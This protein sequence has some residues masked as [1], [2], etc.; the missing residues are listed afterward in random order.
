MHEMGQGASLHRSAGAL[1]R[2]GDSRL[3]GQA[4]QG[5]PVRREARGRYADLRANREIQAGGD[6]E[7]RTTAPREAAQ[8]RQ[9]DLE[10]HLSRGETPGCTTCTL[11]RNERR[12]PGC[13]G[14]TQ[15]PGPE[16]TTCTLSGCTRCTR[17][18]HSR[19]TSQKE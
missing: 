15:K 9:A 5:I 19:R 11:R 13:T 1:P 18:F 4:W 3:C 16:C 8:E 17:T 6:G 12:L 2:P 10:L 14:C 7:A